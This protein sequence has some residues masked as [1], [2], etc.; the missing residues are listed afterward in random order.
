MLQTDELRK[1]SM[2]NNSPVLEEEQYMRR[3]NRNITRL[4]AAVITAAALSAC[5]Q[6][7]KEM[8]LT[9]TQ[10]EETRETVPATTM[11]EELEEKKELKDPATLQG[12]SI[13]DQITVNAVS[14]VTGVPDKA[15]LTFGVMTSGDNVKAAQD[16]NSN[17][18][19]KI[20]D[21]LNALNVENK[22]IKTTDYSIY[23]NYTYDNDTGAST[24]SSY[25]VNTT[26]TVSDIPVEDSA[27]VISGCVEAGINNMTGITYTCS[28]YDTL[29][30]QALTA[31]V[32][33][34]QG[35]AQ[36]LADA[37]GRTLG[38]VEHIQEGYSDDGIA[39]GS[40]KLEAAASD[41]SGQ[42]EPQILP[43]SA[44][45][46][47]PFYCDYGINITLGENFY[48]NY[49]LILLDGAKITFGDNVFIAP[50]CVFTTAAHPIDTQQRNQGLEIA[51]PI[52]VGDNVWFGANVT[53]LPGV[54][55][56]SDTVIGAGSVV[57]KDIPSGVVAVGNPC[58]VLREITD[59]D[60]NK[61]PVF[62]EARK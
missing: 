18:S 51:L 60:K 32:A 23:P 21:T 19:K 36:A 27:S 43:G 24:I 13:D 58:R 20:I 53:V 49:N 48:S 56:G 33:E 12:A 16:E 62:S 47:A 6:G 59:A 41:T 34:A 38:A 30:E 45:V 55:I 39:Y 11:A 26:L 17:E 1:Q 3:M 10:V 2:G 44:V 57:T 61:Y 5:S 50:N 31:A 9:G 7:P 46:T 25:T 54:T 40:A 35:K 28:N 52:T 22:N 8:A 42:A 15:T 37:S 14:H 29:Y 4:T